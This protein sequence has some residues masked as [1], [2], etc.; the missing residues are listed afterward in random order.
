MKTILYVFFLMTSFSVFAEEIDDHSDC[1]SANVSSM[2]SNKITSCQNFINSNKDFKK[3]YADR[4]EL[5]K[6]RKDFLAQNGNQGEAT[7]SSSTSSDSSEKRCEETKAK[8]TAFHE[9]SE[10]SAGFPGSI[11]LMS[12]DKMTRGHIRALYSPGGSRSSFDWAPYIDY[13]CCK[14]KKQEDCKK[15]ARIKAKS[16]ESVAYV[17][18]AYGRDWNNAEHNQPVTASS[19]GGGGGAAAKNGGA[20]AVAAA[21]ATIKCVSKGI[22]TLDYDACKK[23][24]T[25][26]ELIEG[27]QQVGYAT[28][29]LVYKDKIM[30]S[31]LK[32]SS[33]KNTAT[34]ALKATGESLS[35]QQDMYNQRTAVDAT[36]LAYLYSIYNDM[37]KSNDIIAK[38]SGMQGRKPAGLDDFDIK[39]CQNATNGAGGF[40]LTMNQQQMDAMKTKLIQIATSAGSNMILA[41]LLGKRADDVNKAIAKIDEF[42]P[43]DPFVVSEEEAISTFCKQ[44]P[45][46]PQCL[47]GGL[48]RTFD[49]I[50]DNVITF[51]EGGTGTNYGGSTGV[52]PGASSDVEGG[53]GGGQ[54]V[55]PVG[56]TI[57]S[58]NKGGGIEEST[59]ATVKN[60]PGGSTGGGGGGGGASG[61]GG[62]GGG[63]PP[64]AAQGN[65]VTAAVQGK[66]PT[67]SGGG[68]SLSV[69]GGFGINKKQGD[70]KEEN[71]FGKLFGKDAPKGAGVVNFRDIASVGKKGDNIF[72]MISKR[73][74]TV[75]ADKRLLEY[76]LAK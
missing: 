27:V 32:H 75:A 43:I 9:A 73:Y 72:D 39:S 60:G 40:A 2:D 64:Q 63:N 57:G 46:M 76:E 36:K 48:E 30:D 12:C 74:G 45:G 14:D 10:E 35:M 29:E 68:G 22:E 26:L 21:G 25:Q 37:P 6:K 17:I 23:F 16:C 5:L 70:G 47:T 15:S 66:T 31:Q 11:N 54:T 19:G 50:S 34:G 71:P 18:S 20:A 52:I 53:G 28:Q 59:A 1:I 44:N 67:Y 41:N 69:V 65:S 55:T 4:L 51:G 62:G 24:Q 38:C 33:D 61:G 13:A 7:A 58:V 42:K 49:T 56:S 8:T 3:E